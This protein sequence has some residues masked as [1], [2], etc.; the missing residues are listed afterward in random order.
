[1]RRRITTTLQFLMLALMA[2]AQLQT[3]SAQ[4]AVDKFVSHSSLRYAS[5]GVTVIDLDSAK[6]IASYRPE[7]A[8][9]TASTMKTVVSSAA[10]GLLGPHF[11]FETPV[12][13]DGEVTDGHFKGNIVIRGTGDPTL[14]SVFLPCQANIVEEIVAALQACGI[15]QVE[16]AVIGDDSLY[17]YPYFDEGWDVGDLAY[18]YG[19]AVHALSFHDN[20]VTDSYTL[21]SHGRVSQ[22]SFSPSVP[23]LKVVS[24]CRGSRGRNAITPYLNYSLPAL[25]LTG[26][27]TGKS[28]KDTY[29]NP[30]P[31]PMLVDSVER[32][33]LM[34]PGIRYDYNVQAIDGVDGAT[35]T[36]LVVHKSPELTEII[37]SLLD[38]SDNMFA[39][40]L[41][42]AI[43]AREWEVKD[44]PNM[45]SNLDAIGVDAVKRWL[46]QQGVN[47]ESLFMRD[48]SGL[49]RAN[50]AP[51]SFFG[52][53]LSMMAHRRFD[54]V[55]LCDLM[56]KAA[57]RAGKTL[58]EDP[59]SELIVL[60]SGSMRH[61][62]CFVGYYPAQEP[63]YAFAVL[64]NNFTCSQASIREQ[65]G[66]F[67][68][69]LFNSK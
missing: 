43:G 35:R 63:R 3:N 64:V 1:M 27:T 18:D 48:G 42:R 14:G 7:Q 26:E 4:E 44:S 19:T 30:T 51:V 52:E 31:A 5:V 9:I 17:A 24:R 55:R 25:V 36:L 50:K 12:Y 47:T 13:L 10:L 8:N 59:L 39:H 56:P 32:A 46:D 57:G 66:T 38:R 15:T 61:V 6:T 2:A 29:A 69:N 21:D 41:L 60:K 33:L 65:I 20:L 54:G 68:C 58:K 49:A 37:T 40:A 11:R 22:S 28:Y 45:P 23:G 16:G 34:A 53:M 62:Q 67:L